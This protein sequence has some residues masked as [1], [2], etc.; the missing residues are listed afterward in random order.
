[1]SDAAHKADLQRILEQVRDGELS[2]AD[3]LRRFTPD[4][5]LGFAKVDLDRE[6]RCG[7]PEVVFCAGKTP[8]Q[9]TEIAQAVL[10]RSPRVLLTR[11]S[12]A[13][14]EALQRAV[15]GACFDAVSACLWVDPEPLPRQGH[16]AL[17]AA[18]TSDL[19]VAEEARITAELLGNRVDCHYDVGVAGLHRLLSRLPAVRQA[20]VVIAV[21]GM[22]GALA[23]V[24]AGQVSQPVVAVPTS[25]GYGLH[26]GGITAL[27]AMLNSCAAGVGVVN[28]DNGFGA[29]YL[30][31]LINRQATPKDPP[32]RP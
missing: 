4:A 15:P 22:E 8:A 5:D 27:L 26:L 30:A 7:F 3:A 6:A 19:P 29:G 18:G 1:M 9:A 11:A 10:S 31:A 28:V 16:I 20:E 23:S 12:P 24:V 2:V 32:H 21:A 25:V 14:A 13:H 17:L